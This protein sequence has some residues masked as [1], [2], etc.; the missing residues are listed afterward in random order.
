MHHLTT[1][2]NKWRKT[3]NGNQLIKIHTE[4]G[5]S[6]E[7]VRQQCKTTSAQLKKVAYTKFVA[8]RSTDRHLFHGLFSRTTWLSRHLKVKPIWF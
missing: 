7:D 4:N 2:V 5:L 6:I 8:L 1:K 3:T